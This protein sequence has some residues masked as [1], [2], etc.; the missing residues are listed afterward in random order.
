M[1]ALN[2]QMKWFAASDHRVLLIFSN[3]DKDPM[4]VCLQNVKQMKRDKMEMKKAG[5]LVRKGMDP[6]RPHTKRI[7]GKDKVVVTEKIM[8]K[9]LDQNDDVNNQD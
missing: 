3:T 2:V 1:H 9:E 5:K 8:G 7:G 6:C 4:K